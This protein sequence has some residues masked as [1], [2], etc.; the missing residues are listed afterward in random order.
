MKKSFFIPVLGLFSLFMTSC[1]QNQHYSTYQC[2]M[3]C[4]GTK[5]YTEAGKCPVCEMP[6]EGVTTSK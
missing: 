5:T 1:S 2:P 4:E 3:H 6:L